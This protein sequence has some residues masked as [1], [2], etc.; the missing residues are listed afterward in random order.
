MNLRFLRTLIAISQHPTLN[1]AANSIGLSHSAVSLQIKTLEEELNFSILDRSKRPPVLTQEGLALVEH[2]KRMELIAGDIRALADGNQLH[3]KV[4]VG[5]VP[6][7]L[8]KLAAPALATIYRDHPDLRI[9]LFSGL[10]QRL[11]DHVAGGV[12]DLALVSEPDHAGEDLTL[13]HIWKEPFQLIR[14]VNEHQSDPLE[15][16]TQRPYI[17]F[18]RRTWLS[19]KI[20]RY[21][22]EHNIVVQNAME[23]DSIEAVEALVSHNLGISVIPKR[24]LNGEATNLVSTLFAEGALER[25]V[26]LVSRKASP[27]HIFADNFAQALQMALSSRS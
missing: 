6:S 15:L 1:A 25:N 23:V 17:W 24:A 14:S 2:A 11:I 3:G 7:C 13:T 12:L 9:E 22:L 26:V 5:V 19:R 16:L 21:F 18:D 4:T 20:E 27:R 10:S 8:T